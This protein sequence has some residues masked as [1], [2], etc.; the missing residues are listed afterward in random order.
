MQWQRRTLEMADSLDMGAYI[1]CQEHHY[2]K[3]PMHLDEVNIPGC[4]RWFRMKLFLDWWSTAAQ[5]W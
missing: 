4:R 5:Q 2:I 1:Y 3:T